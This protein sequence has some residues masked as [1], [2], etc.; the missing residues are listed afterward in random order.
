MRPRSLILALC[1]VCAALSLSACGSIGEPLYPATYIPI[2]ISDLNAV[3]RGSKILVVFTIPAVS[4]DGLRLKEVGAIDMRAGV[5]PSVAFQTGAWAAA[6]NPS[7]SLLPASRPSFAAKSPSPDSS[8]AM[9][10]LALE[11]PASPAISPVGPTSP[12]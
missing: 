5:T 7:P 1:A 12:W 11:S 6:L 3:Q 9:S 8:A 10:S 2:A 4:T